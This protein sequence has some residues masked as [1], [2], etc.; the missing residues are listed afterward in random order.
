MY[1]THQKSRSQMRLTRNFECRACCRISARLLGQNS[2]R[3][4]RH[5]LLLYT[6][7]RRDAR[8]VL[9]LHMVHV[10]SPLNS[11]EMMGHSLIWDIQISSARAEQAC[12]DH[13]VCGYELEP[14]CTSAT[15]SC[16]ELCEGEC[17]VFGH[18]GV[19]GEIL[20][21]WPD[22]G[23]W[24]CGQTRRHVRRRRQINESG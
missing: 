23:H 12:M 11:P 5:R 18:I 21:V 19:G 8:P 14:G 3:W 1:R 24:D 20:L 16:R 10:R 7:V 2:G 22:E 17:Q 15:R 9:R 6:L 13:R 4:Q